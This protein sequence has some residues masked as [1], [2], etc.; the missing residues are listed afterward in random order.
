MREKCAP[1]GTPGRWFRICIQNP[2]HPIWLS[3]GMAPRNLDKTSLAPRSRVGIPCKVSYR[4]RCHRVVG[5][6]PFSPARM[7]RA[8]RLSRERKS[9]SWVT[10]GILPAVEPGILPG[11]WHARLATRPWVSGAGPGGKMRPSCRQNTCRQV[12]A[13]SS[14]AE[15]KGGP[16]AGLD[17]ACERGRKCGCEDKQGIGADS[18]LCHPTCL[19]VRSELCI[20]AG[21]GWGKGLRLRPIRAHGSHRD[22]DRWVFYR[23]VAL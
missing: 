3:R 12:V 11:G 15:G 4:Q 18:D 9:V 16:G 13:V 22:N 10:A 2:S 8:R 19:R 17:N 5:S 20:Q 14:C 1:A 21:P 7:I 23:L 6:R